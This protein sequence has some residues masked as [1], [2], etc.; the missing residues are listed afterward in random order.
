MLLLAA[1]AP[2]QTTYF[3]P[4]NQAT[5][6]TCNVI[7][8]GDSSTSSPTWSNQKYQT[9]ILASAL[10][11]Q[12]GLICEL[13]FAPCGS[14]V[15]EFATIKI[16]L[17]TTTATT[18]VPAFASNLV[19]RPTTVLDTTNYRWTN[20]AN[21]WNRI[22]L[23]K[24]YPFIGNENLVIDIEVTGVGL[25]GGGLGMHR[26]STIERLYAFGW[27]GTAPLAGT[28]DLAALKVEVCFDTEDLWTF[29]AGCQGSNAQVPA[30]SHTG[31][32]RLG[33]IFSADLANA[34]PG[35]ALLFGGFRNDSFRN[36]VSLP[37]EMSAVGAPGCHLYVDAP[38]ILG[39]G[40]NGS[41]NASLSFAVPRDSAL[42]CGKF[43]SQ[44]VPLDPQANALGFVTSNYGRALIGS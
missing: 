21:T 28:S 7:P 5:A 43:Y 14:G 4:D 2:A 32:S 20:V 12:A 38:L 35:A 31:S 18:L 10:G 29:G 27:T 25:P 8:F 15:R 17:A 24:A 3:I 1:A 22:G 34:R 6:G 9:L 30:L 36:T 16:Q 41:G 13:A 40:V 37:W 39:A 19:T 44:Y 26:S 42:L 23:Q 33:N 11:N